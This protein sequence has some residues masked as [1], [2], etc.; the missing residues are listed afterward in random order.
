MALLLAAGGALVASGANLVRLSIAAG[1]ANAM[2]LPIVLGFLV[3][4]RPDRLAR[5]LALARRLRGGDRLRSLD[6]GRGR[7][8][9][10]GRRLVVK[11]IAAIGRLACAAA[12]VQGGDRRRER[13]GARRGTNMKRVMD[14]LWPVIGLG[15]VA[16]TFWL[17][18]KELHGLSLAAVAAAV[19]AISPLRWALAAASTGRRLLRSRLVRPDRARPSRPASSTGASSASSP[20]RPTRSATTSA[21]RSSP[22]RSCAIAPI[23]PR[24][25]GWREVGRSSP[26]ARPPYAWARCCSAA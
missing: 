3:F 20:S 4:S 24:D 6:R 9:L 17:L 18:F 23:R 5:S 16:F 12:V 22:A 19:G 10:G 13:R 15:A 2:L 8:R 26:S 14:V 11:P 21:L 25:W 7:R 1:V